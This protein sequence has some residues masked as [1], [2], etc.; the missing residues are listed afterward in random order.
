METTIFL[1]S[2]GSQLFKYLNTSKSNGEKSHSIPSSSRKFNSE[3]TS[4]WQPNDVQGLKSLFLLTWLVKFQEHCKY[5][6]AIFHYFLSLSKSYKAFNIFS[7]LFFFEIYDVFL[8][9]LFSSIWHMT[10]Y[11][12]DVIVLLS[13]A[14][15]SLLIT[16]SWFPSHRIKAVSPISLLKLPL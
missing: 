2:S 14:S 13:N 15:N 8:P 3:L 4:Q 10:V 11:I 16:L 12:S 1:T 9:N 7:I 6:I 5:W